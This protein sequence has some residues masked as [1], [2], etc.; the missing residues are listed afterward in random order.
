MLFIYL[1]ISYQ[2][3]TLNL[4][5][6]NGCAWSF[7]KPSEGQIPEKIQSFQSLVSEN[8]IHIDDSNWNQVFPVP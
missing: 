6:V 4:G 8:V 5:S 3:L 2:I 7:V 1:Y